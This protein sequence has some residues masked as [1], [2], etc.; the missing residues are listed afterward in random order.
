MLYGYRSVYPAP[1]FVVQS[2]C[3]ASG[4]AEGDQVQQYAVGRVLL[5]YANVPVGEE[6]VLQ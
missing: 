1:N 6:V 4:V 3:H 2:H 5:D